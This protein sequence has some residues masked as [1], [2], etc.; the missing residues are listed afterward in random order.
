MKGPYFPR[1]Y[2]AEAAQALLPW[3]SSRMPIPQSAQLGQSLDVRKGRT[4]I[5]AEDSADPRAGSSKGDARRCCNKVGTL[6]L[7]LFVQGGSGPATAQLLANGPSIAHPPPAPT[8]FER[9][10][11]VNDRYGLLTVNVSEVPF[12]LNGGDA[13][14]HRRTT[15]GEDRFMLV[16]VATDVKRPAFDQAR[17][18]AVLNNASHKSYQADG[19]LRGRPMIHGTRWAAARRTPSSRYGN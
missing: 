1:N 8:G 11:T 5:V 18:A 12:W 9:A 7:A 3:L 15:H 4:V 13:F 14:V 19:S 16:D 6:T 17:L 10:L 2:R